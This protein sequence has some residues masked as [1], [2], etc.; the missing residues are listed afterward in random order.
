MLKSYNTQALNWALTCLPMPGKPEKHSPGWVRE[1]SNQIYFFLAMWTFANA[2]LFW[3][4]FTFIGKLESII[5]IHSSDYCED[6]MIYCIS[7]RTRYGM[8]QE[9]KQCHGL[10]LVL[11]EMLEYANKLCTVRLPVQR[12]YFYLISSSPGSWENEMRLFFSDKLVEDPVMRKTPRTIFFTIGY[13]ERSSIWVNRRKAGGWCYFVAFV[14]FFAGC[15][16]YHHS[17]FQA[18]RG[19]ITSLQN[20]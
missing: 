11:I 1:I 6:N 16:Y 20:F 13:G 12:N 15:K 2:Q 17:G 4:S 5:V 9:L 7:Y 14:D 8:W 18:T 3:A 10:L 19:L